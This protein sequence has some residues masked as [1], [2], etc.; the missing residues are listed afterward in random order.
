M[1]YEWRNAP[2]KLPTHLLGLVQALKVIL[3]L[4]DTLLWIVGLGVALQRIGKS[5]R[6]QSQAWT[7]EV[8]FCSNGDQHRRETSR[9]LFDMFW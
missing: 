6:D 9:R 2:A 3:L 7:A 8:I 5:D 4:E 1:C